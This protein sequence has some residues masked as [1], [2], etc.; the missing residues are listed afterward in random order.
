MA[1][2]HELLAGIADHIG[3]LERW[4]QRT[5]EWWTKQQARIGGING[6]TA[7]GERTDPP[8]DPVVEPKLIYHGLVEDAPQVTEP[9][10][11]T[12]ADL[13]SL[14]GERSVT[15]HPARTNT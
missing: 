14:L 6:T 7:L 4:K 8:I 10:P 2:R 9:Q 5:P 3:V 15:H 1:D 11:D 13:D 12:F